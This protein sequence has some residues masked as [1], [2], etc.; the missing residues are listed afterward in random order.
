MASRERETSDR[1]D[2][3]GLDFES[4]RQR[5]SRQVEVRKDCPYLDTVNRQVFHS[6]GSL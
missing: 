5:S 3:E 1:V 4:K 6:V 2:E